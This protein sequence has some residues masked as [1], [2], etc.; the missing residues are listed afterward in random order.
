M[1]EEEKNKKIVRG[2]WEEEER[3][4]KGK[5]GMFRLI[6]IFQICLEK[7]ANMKELL[8]FDRSNLID[9]N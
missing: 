5:Q 3:R 7:F 8:N 9:S 6:E 1:G 2:K 4:R